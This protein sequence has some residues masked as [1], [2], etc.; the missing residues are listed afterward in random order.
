MTISKIATIATFLDMS[1]LLQKTQNKTDVRSN[2][3]EA[4]F[5]T[6]AERGRGFSLRIGSGASFAFGVMRD[7]WPAHELSS[8][9]PGESR[10]A[11]GAWD[12]RSRDGGSK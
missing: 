3:T 6:G 4:R 1:Y 8:N 9:P 10:L 2:S 12:V 11:R 7:S 5:I